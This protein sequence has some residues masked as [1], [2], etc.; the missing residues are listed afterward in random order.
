M[1]HLYPDSQAGELGVMADSFSPSTSVFHLSPRLAKCLPTVS[2][3]HIPISSPLL[4]PLIQDHFGP[5]QSIGFSSTHPW[6]YSFSDR[7]V[8]PSNNHVRPCLTPFRVP[9]CL[10]TKLGQGASGLGPAQLSCLSS[11]RLL[12]WPVGTLAREAQ[13]LAVAASSRPFRSSKC[14]VRLWPRIPSSAPSP[15]PP[16]VQAQLKSS[17]L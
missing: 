11:C 17:L 4:L 6:G 13:Q 14:C 8:L 1:P 3:V 5:N 10:H 12:R 15:N 2:P 9:M 16:C 7:S